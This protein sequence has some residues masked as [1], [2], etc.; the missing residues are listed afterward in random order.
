MIKKLKL[1][2]CKLTYTKM[3]PAITTCIFIIITDILVENFMNYTTRKLYEPSDYITITVL[4]QEHLNTEE[5]N[6]SY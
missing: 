5:L 6:L 4:E 3:H 1:R 2:Y